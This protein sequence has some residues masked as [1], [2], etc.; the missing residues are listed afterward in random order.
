MRDDKHGSYL[1]APV[2]VLDGL[3]DYAENHREQGG[4]V[5]SVLENDFQRAIGRADTH[6]L[7]GIKDIMLYVEWEIPSTC[8]GSP[9]K[10]A[11]WLTSTRDTAEHY[12]EAG[13]SDAEVERDTLEERQREQEGV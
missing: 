11:A 8:H 2:A 6:S 3:W 5:T 7:A 1:T 13:Y 10:V 9:E 12:H 4:F